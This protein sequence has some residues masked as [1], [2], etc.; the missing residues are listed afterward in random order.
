MIAKAPLATRLP[1]MS[2]L[3][4]GR[5]RSRHGGGRPEGGDAGEPGVNPSADDPYVAQ[6]KPDQE[7][8]R[9]YR[10]GASTQ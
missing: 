2:G 6:G 8:A 1:P 10:D 4:G 5:S 9:L 7:W 3:S